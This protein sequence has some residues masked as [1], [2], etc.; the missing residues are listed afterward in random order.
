MKNLMILVI[1]VVAG[2]Q[3]YGKY[4]VPEVTNADLELLTAST[5]TVSEPVDFHESNYTCD[6]RQHCSQM[7]SCEEATFFIQNCPN[8]KMDGDNDGVPCERQHCN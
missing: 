5:K 3:I 4:S 6:G 7:S 1:I 2:L 8:T